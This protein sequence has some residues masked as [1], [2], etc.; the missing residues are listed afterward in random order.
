MIPLKDLLNLT[1]K[2]AIVTGGAK[3]IGYG[4]SYRLA[5]AG[6]KVLVADIDEEAAQKTAQE[7]S[8]KGW[9]IEAIK[10]DVS[11]ETDVKRMVGAC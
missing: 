5:E 8:A 6:A 4:I 9:A 7:L 10:V 2:V 1:G 11:S 3:G